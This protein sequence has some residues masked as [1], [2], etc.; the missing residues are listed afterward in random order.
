MSEGRPY[1]PGGYLAP[2]L[3][4]GLTGGIGSGSRQSPSSW[5]PSVP[6]LSTRMPWPAR[7]SN[8][9]CRPHGHP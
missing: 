4:V 5:Q 8:P 1:D 6:S 3:R 2:T 7:S 9:V